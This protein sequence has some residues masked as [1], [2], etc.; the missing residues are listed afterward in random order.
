MYDCKEIVYQSAKG[1][2]NRLNLNRV[3]DDKTGTHP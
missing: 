2:I 1:I 3:E